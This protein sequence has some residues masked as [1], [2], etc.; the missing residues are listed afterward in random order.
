MGLGGREKKPKE[1]GLK[2]PFFY[3]KFPLPNKGR[4]FTVLW[5]KS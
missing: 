2:A 5:A 3:K 4:G 1:G